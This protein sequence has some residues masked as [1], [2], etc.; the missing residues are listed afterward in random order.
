MTY[1]AVAA[2]ISTLF[3]ELKVARTAAKIAVNTSVTQILFSVLS[4]AERTKIVITGKIDERIVAKTVL[5]LLTFE[6]S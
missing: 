4:T 2:K 3:A 6:S 5:A 1:V